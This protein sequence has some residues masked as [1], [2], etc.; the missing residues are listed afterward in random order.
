[1]AEQEDS[2]ADGGVSFEEAIARVEAI[3]E[4]I[5]SGEA[6]LEESIAEYEKGAALIKRCQAVLGRAERR[7]AELTTPEV[8][9]E[10]EV[11]GGGEG[12]AK[13]QA[14]GDVGGG[15]A[16]VVGGDAGVSVGDEDLP[17]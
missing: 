3:V 13:P 2:A 4:R 11:D 7:I 14:A 5:E 16:R 10:V 8:P 9:P 15:K 12:E 6:G 17:F 1:M